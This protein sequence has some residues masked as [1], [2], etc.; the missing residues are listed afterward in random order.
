VIIFPRTKA[1][2]HMFKKKK[3]KKSNHQGHSLSLNDFD[4]F[5]IVYHAF[6]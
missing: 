3:K 1:W 6:C 4:S 2:Y 5:V